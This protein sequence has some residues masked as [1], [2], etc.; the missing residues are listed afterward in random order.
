M[1]VFAHAYLRTCSWYYIIRGPVMVPLA[2]IPICNYASNLLHRIRNTSC[3]VVVNIASALVRSND[4]SATSISILN[5]SFN[6]PNVLLYIAMRFAKLT[7][8]YV[9]CY[10][11]LMRDHV[12]TFGVC[13]AYFGHSFPRLSLRCEPRYSYNC[14]R[15]HNLQ[16]HSRR[17]Y[18]TSP[19]FTR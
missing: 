18:G 1:N 11:R 16:C 2:P 3:N 13:V 17:C 9:Q 5:D 4:S 7:V 8:Y 15:K 10:L 14:I 6:L 12:Q 19:R